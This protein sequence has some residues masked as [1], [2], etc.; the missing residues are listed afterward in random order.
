MSST[1]PSM[2]AH[3]HM[4]IQRQFK[5]DETSEWGEYNLDGEDG[6]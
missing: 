3:T 1:F 4:E 6:G 5:N 2:V